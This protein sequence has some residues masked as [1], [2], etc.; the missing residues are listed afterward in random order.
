MHV[1]ENGDGT[2]RPALPRD[3]KSPWRLCNNRNCHFNLHHVCLRCTAQLFCAPLNRARVTCP[4]RCGPIFFPENIF[5]NLD[6]HPGDQPLVFNEFARVEQLNQ[7]DDRLHLRLIRRNVPAQPPLP[8]NVGNDSDSD[9]ESSASDDNND[10]R[11]RAPVNLHVVV[12]NAPPPN[13]AP[14]APA[15]PARVARD[16]TVGQQ[17]RLYYHVD[18]DPDSWLWTHLAFGT[19][20]IAY[21]AM[22]PYIRHPAVHGVFILTFGALMYSVYMNTIGNDWFHGGIHTRNTRLAAT[23]DNRFNLSHIPYNRY[24]MVFVPDAGL[25]H[26]H[27]VHAGLMPHDRAVNICMS[28]LVHFDPWYATH[29]R[30]CLDT[31]LYYFQCCIAR[32]NE[33]A[34]A[35]ARRGIPRI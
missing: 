4:Q 11:R 21:A 22:L 24:R 8:L 28:T 7:G 27:E 30:A 9:S 23:T 25:N 19:A 2:F 34:A 26:L 31:A 3:T 5:R 1:I 16:F 12:N 20:F 15:P 35:G 17:V 10:A 32:E 33:A 6:I 29:P 14:P 13:E 18:Y